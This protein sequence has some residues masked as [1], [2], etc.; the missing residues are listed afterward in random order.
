MPASRHLGLSLA[1]L[2][3]LAACQC[4]PL[5][6]NETTIQM[7]GSAA[8]AR[9]RR[10]VPDS[11][12]A[13]AAAS[14]REVAGYF[15]EARVVKLMQKNPLLIPPSLAKPMGKTRAAACK[16][17]RLMGLSRKVKVAM[18]NSTIPFPTA[19]AMAHLEMERKLKRMVP[20]GKG[21]V[22]PTSSEWVPGRPVPKPWRFY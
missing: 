1:L 21:K 22:P 11:Q 20:L 10:T 4:A 7:K 13:A 19:S 8:M 5:E 9:G 18:C 15:T 6:D 14:A 3:F 2:A 16:E 12:V 17:V